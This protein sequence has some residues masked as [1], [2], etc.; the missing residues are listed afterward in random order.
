MLRHGKNVTSAVHLNYKN[1][2]N[3]FIPNCGR[4]RENKQI[5]SLASYVHWIH[6]RNQFCTCFG[7]SHVKHTM[8]EINDCR[9]KPL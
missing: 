4:I 8:K 7:H 6:N 3:N 9:R 1:V 2:K 5:P